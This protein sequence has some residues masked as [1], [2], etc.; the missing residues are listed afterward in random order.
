MSQPLLVLLDL[1]K[2]FEVHCD[3]SG[4]CLGAVLSQEGHPIA[5]KSRHLHIIEQSL[6]IFEKELLAAVIHALDS[7]KLYLLGTTFVIDTDHQSI[8]YFMTQT[9]SKKQMR[10]KNF[11]S[12]FHCQFAHV[13]GK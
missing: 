6:G 5:Y 8:K 9:I 11:L 7:W 12:Q 13:L 3:A 4:N 2:P 10:W 1:K